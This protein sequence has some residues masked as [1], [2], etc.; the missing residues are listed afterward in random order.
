MPFCFSLIDKNPSKY[1]LLRISQDDYSSRFSVSPKQVLPF[2]F[3]SRSAPQGSDELVGTVGLGW[4]LGMVRWL[5][6][7]Y[8]VRPYLSLSPFVSS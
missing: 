3:P 4:G 6:G 7:R 1:L 5:L 2:A 8:Q